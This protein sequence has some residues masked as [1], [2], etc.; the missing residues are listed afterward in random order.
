MEYVK[1][2]LPILFFTLVLLFVSNSS[3]FNLNG[4]NAKH[5]P[6]NTFLKGLIGIEIAVLI[7]ILVLQL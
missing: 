7:L 6:A 5:L 1:I 2:L 4:N 3:L